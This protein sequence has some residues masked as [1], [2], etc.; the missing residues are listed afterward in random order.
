MA[1]CRMRSVAAAGYRSSK[2]NQRPPKPKKSIWLAIGRRFKRIC[3]DEEL[4][5][6]RLCRFG[7]PF[8]E[9]GIRTYHS[10]PM[11]HKTCNFSRYPL[12]SA[13]ETGLQSR[14]VIN[15]G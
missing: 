8:P 4:K 10:L 15:A 7:H 9:S 2:G 3:G 1:S 6:F 11:L 12:L 13:I 5:S 14:W